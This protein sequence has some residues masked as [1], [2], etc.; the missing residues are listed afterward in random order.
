M[1]RGRVTESTV[2]ICL[3]VQLCIA[4][5]LF[6]NIKNFLN[7]L[8]FLLLPGFSGVQL[9]IALTLFYNI[10]NSLNNLGFLLL[11]GISVKQKKQS[12]EKR[13]LPR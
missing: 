12:W 10:K 13:R 4:L 6:Y 9:C 7:N 8:G 11:P 1:Y 2:N 5:T 3:G